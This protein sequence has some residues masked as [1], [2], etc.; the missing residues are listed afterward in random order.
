[1]SSTSTRLPSPRRL[2]SALGPLPGWQGVREFFAY[3]GVWAIGVRLLRRM[4]I[5]NKMLLVLGLVALPM[6][7]MLVQLLSYQSQAVTLANLNASGARLAAAVHALVDDLDAVDNRIELGASADPQRLAASLDALREA[8]RLAEAEGLQM[9][10]PWEALEPSMARLQQGGSLSKEGR[11]EALAQAHLALAQLQA[12]TVDS[13]ALLLTRDRDQQS[14]SAVAYVLAPAV[15]EQL[16]Q[17]MRALRGHLALQDRHVGDA[18]RL[19]STLLQAAG[20][21]EGLDLQLSRLRDRLTTAEQVASRDN[22]AASLQAVQT[23]VTL[24]RAALMD[25]AYLGAEELV[26]I[27]GAAEAATRAL[28]ELRQARVAWLITH[29]DQQRRQAQL[30]RW[31]MAAGTATS[32]ALALYLFYAFYLVMRGGLSTLN[33]QMQRLSRGD[34]SRPIRPRGG[35]E[36][37]ETLAAVSI[38]VERLGELLGSVRHGSGSVSQAAQQIATGNGDLRSR[39]QR[40][41]ESLE[42]VVD[43][44][45]RYSTQLE[46]CGAQVERVV[47]TVQHLRLQS[48]RSRRQME[49]LCETLSQVRLQSQQVQEAVSLIDN[50]AFRTNILALNASVEA[51][52]AGESGRGFAV[53]AQEV[54]SLAMRSAEAARRIGSIVGSSS[55]QIEQSALLSE[56]TGRAIAESDGHIDLIHGAMADVSGL[57]REGQQE[58]A[59]ILEQVR[60]LRETTE[61]NLGLVEQLANAS[62]SLRSHGERLTQ[63]LGNFKIG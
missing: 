43:G 36:V 30:S 59:A 56:D 5:K 54:R 12:A 40:T 61:K 52:K 45:A 23:L 44:V 25:D 29:Y 4:S 37:A 6:L 47:G 39:N 41:A 55:G 13:G 16:W 14:H 7:P 35:D 42:R 2:W 1:M 57:T 15:Q 24:T 21:V 11:S 62:H 60:A 3:H 58:S 51:S 33:E 32:I 19:A 18:P 63:R 17:L 34:L 49:R 50:I 8:R 10:A 46:A 48:T 53:V 28:I 27:R 38:S 31:L 9:I 22:P 20:R 26:S